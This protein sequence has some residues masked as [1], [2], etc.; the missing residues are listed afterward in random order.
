MC[1]MNRGYYL[2]IFAMSCFF[3]WKLFSSQACQSALNVADW[4]M[5]ALGLLGIVVLAWQVIRKR[6]HY[7]S[8]NINILF[9]RID[10]LPTNINEADNMKDLEGQILRISP[11]VQKL[12]FRVRSAHGFQVKKIN[13]RCLDL[14][15][16]DLS[17]DQAEIRMVED[18]YNTSIFKDSDDAHYGRDGYYSDAQGLA[19]N[20]CLYFVLTIWCTEGFTGNLSF[21]AQNHEGFRAASYKRR[22]E[23]GSN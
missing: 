4:L 12:I 18:P 9:T 20:K 21:C 23:V 10:N 11:G 22:L 7:E 3:S 8:G 15:D 14:H 1:S 6:T 16:N 19:R 13:W 17:A 2:A 5:G